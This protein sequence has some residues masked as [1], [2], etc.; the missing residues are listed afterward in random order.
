[1]IRPLSSADAETILTIVND[2]ARAYDGV[3]PGDCWQ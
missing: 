1:M 2:G 3:I